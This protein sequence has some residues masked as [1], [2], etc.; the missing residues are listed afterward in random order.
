MK[1]I[2]LRISDISTI[3]IDIAH[4]LQRVLAVDV[5]VPKVQPKKAL[6]MIKTMTLAYQDGFNMLKKQKRRRLVGMFGHKK[7]VFFIIKKII[8]VIV[9]LLG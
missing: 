4:H 5:N 1:F 3:F 9:N 8:V 6:I 7:V 2:I